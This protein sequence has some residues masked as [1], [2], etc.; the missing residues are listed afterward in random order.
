[1]E[2]KLVYDK[3][4]KNWNEALP[5]GNGKLGAMLF[6]FGDKDRIQLNE[7]SIWSGGF[8]TRYN[9]EAKAKLREIQKECQDKNFDT[10]QN[11]CSKFIFPTY[12]HMTHYQT[13][14]DVWIENIGIPKKK[15]FLQRCYGYSKI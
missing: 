13:A 10:A 11:D 2:N 4:P 12:P 15:Y 14:G 7:D 3:P 1:M 6:G 8:R 5:I 9:T